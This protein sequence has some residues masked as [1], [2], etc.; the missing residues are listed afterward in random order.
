[1]HGS[2]CNAE[3]E[4]VD[5]GG[6]EQDQGFDPWPSISQS[7]ES[8]TLGGEDAFHVMERVILGVLHP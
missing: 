1:M 2:F 3:A 5:R 4:A 6:K 8:P 7:T